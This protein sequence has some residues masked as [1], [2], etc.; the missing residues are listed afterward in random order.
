MEQGNFLA[1]QLDQFGRLVCQLIRRGHLDELGHRSLLLWVRVDLRPFFPSTGLP[2]IA[3]SAPCGAGLDPRVIQEELLVQLDEVLPL[4]RGLVLGEDR[5]HRADGLADPAVDAFVGV[6]IEHLRAFVDAV[7]R[8]DLDAGLVLHVD[9][10]LGDD[11][12]HRDLL[13]SP[14]SLAADEARQPLPERAAGELLEAHHLNL[15]NPLPGHP[16]DCAELLVDTV[17]AQA[18]GQLLADLRAARADFVGEGHDRHGRHSFLYLARSTAS[19]LAMRL[20][21]TSSRTQTSSA[22]VPLAK[23]L[24]TSST[25][26]AGR[27]NQDLRD[28]SEKNVLTSGR[29]ALARDGGRVVGG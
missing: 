5:L 1:L 29:S 9:A 24:K 12:R 8:A 21:L 18:L 13:F 6:D 27:V 25:S 19:A 11:I 26:S 17:E 3:M 20:P 4:L 2:K 7:H 10:R 16:I 28:V 15:R 23:T 14:L 22:R